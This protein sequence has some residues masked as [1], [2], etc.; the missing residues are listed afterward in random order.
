MMAWVMPSALNVLISFPSCPRDNQCTVFACCSI[1][2]EVS[3]LTAATTISIPWLR[4]ASR[5]R[6][7]NLPLPA[8]RPILFD[9]ATS[10]CLDEIQQNF[11]FRRRSLLPN[12][13]DGL[14]CVELRLQKQSKSGLDIVNLAFGKALPFQADRIDTKCLSVSIAD[15]FGIRQDV[16]RNDGVAAD[17]PVLANPAVL[18]DS[19]I[20]ADRR[21]ILDR[22]M[23]CQRCRIRHDDVAA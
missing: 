5:T 11:D 12:G 7:G 4:A 19:G 16:F 8:I 3:S 13:F 1:S 21:M 9:D 14:R 15:G 22:H 6:N 10:G 17:I 2:G 18:V 23:T 20:S